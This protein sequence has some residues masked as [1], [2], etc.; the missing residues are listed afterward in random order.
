MMKVNVYNQKGEKLEK[1]VELNPAIFGIEPNQD[2]VVQYVRVY[3]ANQRQGTASTKTR[4]EISGGGRKPWR[5]KGTGRARHGSI[6]SPLWRGGGKAHGPKPRDYSLKMPQKMRRL[7]LFSTLSQKVR[8]NAVVVLNK[9]EFKE[10]KTK[11][12][13]EI[14]RNLKLEG[15]ILIVLPQSDLMV[16]KSA[17]NLPTVRTTLANNLNAYEVLGTD[18]LVMPKESLQVLENTF[19]GRGG[20]Q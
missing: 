16:I 10:Y 7:A 19:L 20:Q 8:D 18:C 2:S 17:D 1:G 14:L 12:I 6:R 13:T 3:L 15:K 9:L 5:Q 11:R 4:G